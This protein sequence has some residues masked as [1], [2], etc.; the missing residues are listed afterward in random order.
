ML[1]LTG[2]IIG[3]ARKVEVFQYDRDKMTWQWLEGAL[4]STSDFSI[5]YESDDSQN[6]EET[7]LSFE[8]TAIL[9][10]KS[11]PQELASAVSERR[12]GWVR[13]TN[14]NPSYNCI[15]S[16]DRLDEFSRLARQAIKTIQD[17]WRSKKVHVFGVSPA[18][19]LFKFGQMLQAGHHSVYRIYDRPDGSALFIP[20]LEI[21]G[22]EV[23]SVNVE[24]EEQ[25]QI[26]L[27]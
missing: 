18:S 16:K 14:S 26:S 23:V 20:A 21:T 10:K 25:H 5:S 11:L 19:V 2:R 7:I 12:M 15:D 1:V 3:E 8:L 22:N 24:I 13:I 17:S 9:D 6:F 27:R 4:S